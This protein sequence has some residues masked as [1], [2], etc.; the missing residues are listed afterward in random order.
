MTSQP[1]VDR[2]AIGAGGAGALGVQNA[3]ETARRHPSQ[4]KSL[5]LLSGE[6]TRPGLE[7]LHQ[8]S[9]LPELFVVDD[10]DEYPP[11]QEAMQLLYASASCPSK[12]LIHYAA[13]EKAPWLWYEPFDIGKVPPT[14]RH[15]TDL[16]ES[17][18]ELPGIIVQ[19]FATTLLKTPGVA[20]PDGVAAGPLLVDVELNNAVARAERDLVEARKIDPQAQIRPEISMSII[21]QDYQ[22]IG[23]LTSAL[24][25]LN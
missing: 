20:P 5:V 13:V 16:F 2:N 22:R 7:F 21:A 17:H 24:A 8:A 23:D 10:R 25:A 4:L 9:Q 1:G 12:K 3:V 19:W 6:T 15:G 14:G 18:F 11:T